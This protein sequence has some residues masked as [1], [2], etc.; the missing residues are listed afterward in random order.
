MS[1]SS[2]SDPLS[3]YQSS[4]D[5]TRLFNKKTYQDLDLDE[6]VSISSGGAVYWVVDEND[7]LKAYHKDNLE[8]P[9]VW[10]AQAGSQE[11]FMSCPIREVLYCGTRGPGKT[12]ALLMDYL[13]HVGQG[14]GEEWRGIIFRESFPDLKD[15]INKAKKWIPKVF[16]TAVYNKQEKTWTFAEGETL[17]FGF[18]SSEEDYSKYHGHA[19][20]FIGWEELTNWKSHDLFKL[21]IS[22][23]RSS[24]KG[25]PLKIRATCNPSGPGHNWVKARYGLPTPPSRY[26]TDIVKTSKI[27]P[28]TGELVHE[29]DR[30]AI[31]GTIHENLI[32]LH[33]QPDYI[34][35]IRASCKDK[36]TELAW[37]YGSWNITSGGMF[38]DV[39]DDKIHVLP[40]T[41]DMIPPGW[42]IDR[43]YDH[44]QSRPFSVGFWAQ[45]N[46]E[47]VTL[48]DGRLVGYI[49]GDI[50]RFEE[51]YGWNG[52]PNEGERMTAE[53]IAIG[54]RER[55]RDMGLDGRVRPG[56]AD[57]SIFDQW[58]PGKSVAGDMRRKGVK[59]L[60]ADKGPGSRKQGWN[61]VRTL[62]TNAKPKMGIDGNAY[63]EL[64]GLFIAEACVQFIR[65]F[66]VLSRDKK[67]PDDVD[68][69]T[70]DH[71]ADEVRYRCRA[72]QAKR[73]G[74]RKG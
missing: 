62:L 59:W 36:N 43:S 50:I 27:D 34:E 51:W 12:D 15:L 45:S 2:T 33:A 52:T 53:D 14:W 48:P 42:K 30:I 63:R 4:K 46:G 37:I 7:E 44:G 19:Y 17:I 16:P 66:P 74:M 35:T 70:E 5:E 3:Q 69:D 71:I 38:D 41:P 24:K 18:M 60:P 32:L 55:Q 9:L 68:S 26:Y 40:F 39:W 20:P 72:K 65:T 11:A 1:E 13:Q 10:S 49:R 21:M 31:H 58:E 6:I 29:H 22:T 64:P 54:I 25:I 61:Q 73:A 57:S 28:K 8:D 23:N 67:D 56:V 47:P